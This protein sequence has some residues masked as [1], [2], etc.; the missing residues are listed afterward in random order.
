MVNKIIMKECFDYSFNM[1]R[2]ERIG[3]NPDYC[4]IGPQELQT[5]IIFERRNNLFITFALT[6]NLEGLKIHKGAISTVSFADTI[7]ILFGNRYLPFLGLQIPN[8]SF[9]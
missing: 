9:K 7:K 8:D 5:S 1:E 4:V 2:Q 6:T 3:K